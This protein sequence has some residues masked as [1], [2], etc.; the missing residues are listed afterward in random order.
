[1]V[2]LSIVRNVQKKLNMIIP[3]SKAALEGWLAE[4]HRIHAASDM[5]PAFLA[6][7]IAELEN[8]CA[9]LR[10]RTHQKAKPNGAPKSAV[11]FTKRSFAA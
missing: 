11:P 3:R 7:Q 4:L 10:K 9:A 1:V 8:R 5:G 2:N 6:L